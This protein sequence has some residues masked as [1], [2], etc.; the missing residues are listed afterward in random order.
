MIRSSRSL[1]RTPFRSDKHLHSSFCLRRVAPEPRAIAMSRSPTSSGLLPLP[2]SPGSSWALYLARFKAIFHGADASVLVAFWLFGTAP[3]HNEQ[4]KFSD[5]HPRSHQQCILRDHPL[6][7]ARSRRPRCPQICRPTRGRSTLLRHE[8][9]CPIFYTSHFLLN[10][11]YHLQRSIDH[12]NVSHST[13]TGSPRWR[14]YKRETIR[15]H[16]S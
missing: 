5:S 2:G 1:R 9:H 8:T 7:R 15:G 13:H 12:R 6:R 4:G 11:D 14:I 16:L 10:E 3:T